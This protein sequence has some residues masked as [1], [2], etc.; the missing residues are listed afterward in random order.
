MKKSKAKKVKSKKPDYDTTGK[1]FDV[2]F[3]LWILSILIEL[4]KIQNNGK[5]RK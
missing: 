5:R 4:N 3:D 1:F 2:I